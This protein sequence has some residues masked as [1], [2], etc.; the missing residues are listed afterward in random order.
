[1]IAAAVGGGLF[2]VLLLAATQ[3]SLGD[4][5]FNLEPDVP[6]GKITEWVAFFK[7]WDPTVFSK[8]NPSVYLDG[9]A[10]MGG[11]ATLLAQALVK[12]TPHLQQHFLNSDSYIFASVTFLNVFS[13][14]AACVVFYATMLRLSGSIVL[15]SVLAVALFLS[16]QLL[17]I[18]IIRPDFQILLPLVAV[19]H[20][21]VVIARREERF[22]HAV[23]L[24]ASL[25]LLVTIKVSGVMYALFPMLAVLVSLPQT[26]RVRARDLL[27]LVLLAF[28]VFLLCYTALMFSYLYRM[29]GEEL[30][31]LYPTGA[32]GFFSWQHLLT[33][34]PRTYYNY[35]L[36][37]GH[38]IEFIVLYVVSAAV[39]LWFAVT[40]RDP[41][42]LFIVV[43][44]VLFS[45]FSSVT[46]KYPRG[47][48]HLLP[49][50]FAAIG[51]A[52]VR[53]WRSHWPKPLRVGLVTAASV[54]LA[55]SSA[56]SAHYYNARVAQTQAKTAA[57]DSIMRAP[58]RWMVQNIMPG[59]RVC[60]Q[61]SSEW[62]LPPLS[63]LK[64]QI[65]HGPFD[66]PYIDPV[67]M[68][69]FEPPTI[70]ALRAA[71]DF[72]VLESY[73]FAFFAETMRKWAPATQARWD[74]LF[75]ELEARHQP[76]LFVSKNTPPLGV[77]DPAAWLFQD[78][79]WLWVKIYHVGNG[80]E[81]TSH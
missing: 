76:V 67:A 49:L 41:A 12:T 30:I 3:L 16:P 14:A 59:S 57:I 17:A 10:I 7:K 6:V 20:C 40:R 66:Y 42:G 65:I 43:A 73:H 35:E 27:R 50:F 52:L 31:W 60:V 69:K 74:Q 77:Q 29:T 38:G 24:G 37:L 56:R 33:W 80:N 58:H 11:L 23:V 25:A 48:Y 75:A 62:A 26:N 70:E 28:L 63:D 15:S 44:L 8:P 68:A 81:P 4:F 45:L 9:Q 32:L 79:A 21:S 71:C 64:A 51:L 22:W 47:G 1:V 39:V 61:K 72:V 5:E 53:L 2:I 36:V 13:Y 34:L 55:T 18:D 46:L 54:A 78:R 19:F